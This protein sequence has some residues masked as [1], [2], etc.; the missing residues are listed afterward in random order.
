MK[1]ENQNSHLP[2]KF[3]CCFWKYQSIGKP[4]LGSKI[5]Q[6]RVYII[7]QYKYN[8]FPLQQNENFSCK[9]VKLATCFQK[10]TD[11]GGIGKWKYIPILILDTYLETSFKSRTFNKTRK[12]SILLWK[13]KGCARIKWTRCII[14]TYYAYVGAK[15]RY[16]VHIENDVQIYL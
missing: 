4:L 8:P 2:K 11:I 14:Y 9:N 5:T 1:I 16:P 12:I 10:N 7:M 3:Y 13:G 15:I 6:H